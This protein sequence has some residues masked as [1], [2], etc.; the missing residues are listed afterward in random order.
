MNDQLYTYFEDIF[1]IL[2][3]A[4]PKYSCQPLLTKLIGDWKTSLDSN[5]VVGAVFM[6]LSKTFDR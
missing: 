2:L 4:F 1:E 5:Q 6:D 3:S